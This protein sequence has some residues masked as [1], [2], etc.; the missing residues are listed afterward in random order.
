MTCT[1]IASGPFISQWKKIKIDSFQADFNCEKEKEF[2]YDLATYEINKKKL[3]CY[4]IKTIILEPIHQWISGDEDCPG[5][6]KARQVKLS[7][8]SRCTI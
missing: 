7:F 3:F 5:K 4:H 6:E 2:H 8:V 1:N